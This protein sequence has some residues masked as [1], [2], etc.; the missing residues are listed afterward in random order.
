MDR[1]SMR[2]PSRSEMFQGKL[3]LNLRTFLNRSLKALYMI[4][5]RFDM[6]YLI[7]LK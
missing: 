5:R 1:I 2:I 7:V 3:A 4:V 6:F